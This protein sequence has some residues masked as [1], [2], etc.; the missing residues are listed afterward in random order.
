[1]NAILIPAYKPDNKLIDLTDLLLTHSDLAVVVVDDGSDEGYSPVF[2]KLDQRIRLIAYSDNRG[3]GAALKTGIQYIYENLPDCDRIVT[4]DA[5]GQHKYE[6]IMRIIDRSVQ[7][8]G[9]LVLGCREFSGNSI[10]FRSRLGN[11]LTRWVFAIASG[12]HVHDTQTGLRGFDRSGMKLF[13]SVPGDRYEYEINMLL[14]AARGGMPIVEVPIETVYINNNEGSHFHPVRDSVRIYLCII[15]FAASSFISFL[16]DTLLFLL[17]GLV[18][19]LSG[20]ILARE[21]I[22]RIV[23]AS[24]NFTINKNVVFRGDE[25]TIPALVKYILLAAVV[26][27]VDYGV[28][29]LLHKGAGWP[30]LP[31]KIIAQLA[32]YTISLPV[33]G[34]FVYRRQKH[35]E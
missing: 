26:L 6:D 28:V 9:A 5:D 24:V 11:T 27:A 29:L 1:M 8:P 30:E 15:K 35:K 19:A 10:P 16:V 21:I 33:Q 12:V 32:G 17:L 31:S 25:K 13:L 4:V 22:A 34:L 14:A 7:I 23:S 18:P 2:T 20:N 3:K